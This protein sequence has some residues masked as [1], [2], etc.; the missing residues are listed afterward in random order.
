VVQVREDRKVDDPERGVLAGD[1]RLGFDEVLSDAGG[2]GH[3]PR[4]EAHPDDLGQRLEE[5]REP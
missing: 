5:I 1:G 4:A 2:H 3:A